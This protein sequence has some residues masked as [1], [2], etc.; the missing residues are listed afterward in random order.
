[1][2]QSICA[3]YGLS[4]GALCAPLVHGAMIVLA[5]V[6]WPTAKLL[7]YCLGEEHGTTY[8]KAELKTFVSLH[9]QIGTEHLND[10]EVTII[11]AVLDLNDKTVADVMTPIEDVYTL[12][13]DHVLDDAGV[14]E[15]VPVSYTHL[16]LPT[17]A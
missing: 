16:T 6:A 8:R 11:R 1:M 17:K 10:D 2:P 7:D 13:I 3:R 5:P 9:Q 15:L 14:D 12:P 4:I